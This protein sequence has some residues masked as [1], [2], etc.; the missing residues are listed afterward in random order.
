MNT[1]KWKNTLNR[2][3][4]KPLNRK[5]IAGILHVN[6]GN[7]SFR[8]YIETLIL[9][10][11]IIE[12]K[13][14]KLGYA[15]KMNMMSGI[16]DV[17]PKGFG[18]VS[19]DD[20]SEDIYIPMHN[21]YTAMDKDRVLVKIIRDQAH[22]KREGKIVSVLERHTD[23]LTGK[24]IR[25]NRYLYVIPDDKNI[26]KNIFVVN[27]PDKEWINKRVVVHLLQWTSPKRNPEGEVLELLEF[28]NKTDLHSKMILI[29]NGFDDAFP[30]DVLD[31][32]AG[33]GFD[34]NED[35]KNRRDLREKT[36]ITI[37]P[38]TAKDFDDGVSAE[39]KGNNFL[40]GVH[41]ADVSYF[42]KDKSPVDNEAYRRATSVY[43]V[44]KTVPM[45][46]EKLSND[47][48]SL[49]PDE[50]KYAM[51]CMF[52]M[53][54][55]GNIVDYEIFPSVIRSKKRFDYGEAQDVIDSKTSSPF[56][57]DLILLNKAALILRKKYK[58]QGK[59]DFDKPEAEIILNE[60]KEPVDIHQKKR[61]DT[62]KLVEDFMVTANS[63]AA[64][65]ISQSKTQ[66]IY[67]THEVPDEEK[68]NA[69]TNMVSKFGYKLKKPTPANI[70]A[71]LEKSNNSTNEFLIKETVLKSM[72]RAKYSIDNPGHYGLGLRF[73][74]HFT[75]PI[76]RYP[77]LMI[78]RILR[79]L[80]RA[81]KSSPGNLELI[82]KHSSEREWAAE[83]AENDSVDIAKMTFIADN[84]QKTYD[85]IIA[86][87]T[88]FGIFIRLSDIMTD[89]LV[90]FRDLDDDYYKIEEDG[91]S[92]E[93]VHT[94][95]K[96]TVGDNVTVAVKSIDPEKMKL[97]LAIV[98]Y[99]KRQQ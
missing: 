14:G 25:G 35:L 24:L 93:G 59:I 61:L 18:F 64:R 8:E 13:N 52:E 12:L 47:L 15:A 37:D 90:R 80:G 97:D 65:H 81:G 26:V 88:S 40:I 86:S 49:N 31:Y 85:G 20:R 71:M 7:K 38:E 36:V 1:K 22:K 82:A 21:M 77:D 17:N 70:Q 28:D 51:S 69:M 72:K 23:K 46:P 96:I 19:P 92:A 87:V 4:N 16:I 48:C 95:K 50:D 5:E 10:G 73:Y 43:L 44:D 34:V 29:E 57:K 91:F 30:D 9:T 33:I 53:N 67:R 74:T 56:R 89:G 94:G 54:N 39:M 2:K 41:I 58:S 79:A 83:K 42:V 6:P 75:S 84:V 3:F 78:H 76:R 27:E 55:E 66:S 99:E 62:H 63:I 98:N 11:S 60:N 32:T 45:L 68:L